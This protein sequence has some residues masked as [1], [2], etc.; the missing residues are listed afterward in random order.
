[1][2]GVVV[3]MAWPVVAVCE[4]SQIAL[5]VSRGDFGPCSH[6]VQCLFARVESQFSWLLFDAAY[7]FS[8]RVAATVVV[9]DCGMIRDLAGALVK[10]LLTLGIAF[11]FEFILAVA[12]FTLGMMRFRLACAT[13]V[14]ALLD[15]ATLRVDVV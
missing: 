6:I 14:F 1:M 11:V 13:T 5:G 4:N 15:G 7:T 8:S 12:A 10:W 2:G 9:V 3:A